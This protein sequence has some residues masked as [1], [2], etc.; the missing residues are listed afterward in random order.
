MK[1]FAALASVLLRSAGLICVV[2]ITLT[3]AEAGD[4]VDCT[5]QALLAEIAKGGTVTF[6]NDCSITV[7]QQI[8]IDG[9]TTIDASG[10]NVT[11]SGANAVRLFNVRGNLTLIGLNLVDGIA[12]NGG[13]LHIATNGTVTVRACVFSGNVARGADGSDG[14]KGSDSST[15]GGNGGNGT[16][17]VSSAGGAIH[18]LGS[19]TLDNCTLTNNTVTGGSGGA[20][21]DGGSA[22]VGVSQGGDGGDGAGGGAG[23]GGALY[24]KGDLRISN[25][26]I[27]TNRARAGDGGAPGAAGSGAFDGWPGAGGGGA[28]AAGGGIYNARNLWIWNSSIHDNTSTGGDSATAGT[29]A[30]GEGERGFDGGQASGGG[31]SSTWWGVVTNC[32]FYNN[33]AQGG[34]G[35]DGGPGLGSL[36]QAGN[37]GNGGNGIGGAV[38]NSA[39]LTLVNC[40]LTTCGAYGGT[41]GVAGSGAWSGDDGQPGASWGGNIANDYTCTIKASIFSSAS[42]GGCGHGSFADGGYNISSDGTI[43]LGGSSW[44]WTDPKLNSPAMNGGSTTTAGLQAGSPAINKIPAA[45]APAGDQRGMPRPM[46]S[47]SD[48]GAY[49]YEFASP[50]VILQQPANAYAT[51]YSSVTFTVSATGGTPLKYQWRLKG[52]RLPGNAT[53]STYTIASVTPTNAGPYSVVI[54]NSYGSNTSS[55]VYVHLLPAITTQPANVVTNVGSNARFTVVA[56][57]D[58]PLRYQWR[59]NTTNVLDGETSSNLTLVAVGATDIGRY[60]VSISNEYGGVVSAAATLALRPFINSQPAGLTVAPGDTAN[61]SV[62]A[63]GSRPLRYQWRFNGANIAGATTNWLNLPNVQTANAGTYTVVIT[64]FFGSITS[65]P[66]ALKVLLTVLRPPVDQAVTAGSPASF[67]VSAGGTPPLSYQWRFYQTNLVGAVATNFSIAHAQT[68]QIGPYTVVVKDANG[69]ITSSPASLNLLPT[70]LA[71]PSNVV[72]RAGSSAGFCVQAIG[73]PE[74][75]YQWTLNGAPVPGETNACFNLAQVQ[76]DD[77]GTYNVCITNRFGKTNSSPATLSFGLPPSIGVQPVDQAISGGSNALF[78]VAAAGTAPLRYQWQFEG[79]NIAGA[80]AASYT[81]TN[82]QFKDI[83]SY[84]A[85]VTNDFGSVL[86]VAADLN[87]LPTILAQPTDQLVSPGSNA[88]FSVTAT[89]STNLLY[90]WRFCGTNLASA[91]ESLFR[92]S[93]ARP[94]NEG[95]YTV[96]ITNSFGSITSA[97]ATLTLGVAPTVAVQPTNRAINLGSNATFYVS[98]NGTQPFSYQWRFNSANLSGATTNSYKVVG[99]QQSN[100]GSYAVVITNAFGSVTSSNAALDLRP[101]IISPPTNQLVF[102]GSPATF[103][104]VAGGS[105]TLAYQWRKNSTNLPAQTNSAYVIPAVALADDDSYTVRITNTFGSITSAPVT[106]HL[107]PTILT[108][109]TNLNLCVG[110]NAVFRV[111]ATGSGTLSYQWRFNGGDIAGAT[112]S[113]YTRSNLLLSDAGN[114]D[115]L[116]ASSYGQTYSAVAHL[117]VLRPLAISGR[118]VDVGRTNGLAGVTVTAGTNSVITDASGNYAFSG[119]SSNRYTLIPSLA[120]YQFEPTNLPVTLSNNLVLTQEFVAAHDY[121]TI[122]GLITSAVS[123]VAN[124]MVAI[125]LGG[126]NIVA[127]TDVL[128]GGGFSVTNLCPGSYLVV[129]SSIDYVFEPSGIPVTLPQ[130]T[131]TLVFE[132]VSLF[133]ISGQVLTATSNAWAG[134]AISISNAMMTNIVTTDPVGRFSLGRLPQ[135]IYTVTPS[136]PSCRHFEPAS[137]WTVTIGPSANLLFVDAPDAYLIG[138]RFTDERGAPVTNLLVSAGSRTSRTDANGHYAFSNLCAG[139]YTVLPT[140]A[141]YQYEP[142]T[143]QVVVGPASAPNLDF[144]AVR[145]VYAVSGLITQGSNPLRNVMVVAGGV[146]NFTDANG[147]YSIGNL[148]PGRYTVTPYYDCQL[149]NPPTRT[150]DLGPDIDQVNFLAFTNDSFSVRGRVTSDGVNGLSNVLVTAGNRT[151]TTLSDGTYTL[152]HVCP[153]TYDLSPSLTGY[154][155]DPSKRSVTVVSDLNAM[156][157]VAF[158]VFTITGRITQNGEGLA[159]VTVQTSNQNTNT[160]PDGYYWLTGLRASTY[161]VTP[162]QSCSLFNPASRSVTVG[163]NDASGIDFFALTNGVFALRGRIMEAVYPLGRVTLQMGDRQATTTDDGYYSFL[164]VCPGTNAI[165]PSMPGYTFRPAVLPVT[166]ST[167]L[168]GL[169]FT[170]TPVFTITNLGGQMELHSYGSTGTNYQIDASTN[171]ASWTTLTKSPAP[172]YYL[173]TN[174]P[175][176]TNRYYRLSR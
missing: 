110:S 15:V 58:Q 115:V 113:I 136:H 88:T 109:P 8:V 76:S 127:A 67:S 139:A 102:V 83:G 114:Y 3:S 169:N 105:P 124:I 25:C 103:S 135:G 97:Q 147:L 51:Q 106:L 81:V 78:T 117:A 141:C 72:V 119:L 133:S 96:L 13:A 99:A 43:F 36:P 148:C 137:S 150:V 31:I 86:S 30:N 93:E 9:I 4:V 10:H 14:V 59:F 40:T 73:S 164:S 100:I 35:G 128:A 154:G 71:Q 47:T 44:T 129:P 5:E 1:C 28:R 158:P 144:T 162:T 157:F 41:N 57:G 19:L 38:Y 175:A 90:Q 18:N 62:S 94:T 130:D 160:N 6:T 64:N 61:F 12:P 151:T 126:T 101:Y 11:I 68:N 22:S 145:D 112:A 116:V 166:I 26:T 55:P 143:W 80:V 27:A 123:P 20:G 45:S 34:G 42:S 165:L 121:H 16:P 24:N 21:G 140:S 49:E 37:G 65:A 63:E 163:P 60:S 118:V 82:A 53:D 7:S 87:L 75:A 79:T 152:T 155:F 74:L 50:P 172:I 32:T 168:S 84:T 173:D 132:A 2:L 54:T 159:G 85:L 46:N 176:Y 167:D 52:I 23:E 153:G 98:A 95:P 29:S 120:C 77:L 91:T 107:L 66:A 142:A 92:I 125:V 17:G 108:Q 149:F 138:G 134:L 33:A 131:N 146:T 70:I 48:V 174:S 111:G 161:S 39:N 156:D 104:V 171:L 69:S 122:T 56:T 89:G 170:A